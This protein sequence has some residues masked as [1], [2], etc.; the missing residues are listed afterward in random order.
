MSISAFLA[1]ADEVGTA[2][3]LQCK[4]L[5]R[6]LCNIISAMCTRAQIKNWIARRKWNE[7]FNIFSLG[8][9]KRYR[10][11][12]HTII[13]TKTSF[14]QERHR[15]QQPCRCLFGSIIPAVFKTVNKA[16][17]A[18][19]KQPQRIRR[20]TNVRHAKRIG[21]RERLDVDASDERQRPRAKNFNVSRSTADAQNVHVSAFRKI[22]VRYA[23]RSAAG[24]ELTRADVASIQRIHSKLRVTTCG[25]EK[26]DR[27]D[28][29]T[30]HSSANRERER[31][32]E[33][34]RE[35]PVPSRRNSGSSKE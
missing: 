1:P 30:Q 28:L 2:A 23:Q 5:L 35:I 8:S 32:M 3:V 7:V 25:K 27:L 12:A 21:H 18:G 26:L 22:R 11:M 13:K 17:A 4:F 34:E 20:K 16:V 10:K 14:W 15:N 6:N 33:R 29:V 9:K 24:L 31:E 19:G